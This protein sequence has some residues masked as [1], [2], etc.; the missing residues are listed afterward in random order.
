MMVTNIA[1]TVGP[2]TWTAGLRHPIP[3]QT[4]LIATQTPFMTIHGAGR[5]AGQPQAIPVTVETLPIIQVS[6]TM[7]MDIDTFYEASL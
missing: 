7:A 3:A 2:S 4:H 5:S 1:K 6:L